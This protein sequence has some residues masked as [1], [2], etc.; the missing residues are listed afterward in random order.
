M[1]SIL[2]R[3]GVPTSRELREVMKAWI[4]GR[5]RPIYCL[6]PQEVVSAFLREAPLRTGKTGGDSHIT[7]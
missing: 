3:V 1:L 6:H 2:K 5:G 4:V 7:S